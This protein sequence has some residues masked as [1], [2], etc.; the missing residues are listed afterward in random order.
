VQ[1]K[2]RLPLK[3]GSAR[4]ARELL[5]PLRT[6]LSGRAFEDLLQVTSEL[7]AACVE[8]GG[9]QGPMQVTADAC[10]AGAWVEVGCPKGLTMPSMVDPSR[11]P[12]ASGMGLWIVDR[13]AS[14]WQVHDDGA[15]IV[16]HVELAPG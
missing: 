15:R 2:I 8:H 13:L 1:V 10:E 12:G 3:A 9:P 14:D 4:A 5:D 7:V 6:E 11:A 16:L